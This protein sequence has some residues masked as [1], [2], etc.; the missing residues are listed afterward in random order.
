LC[1]HAEGLA[2]EVFESVDEI[3]ALGVGINLQPHAIRELDALG[4][5]ESVVEAGITPRQ[6]AYVTKRGQEIWREPRGVAAGYPW[7]QV[8]VHRGELQRILLDAF[9][10][11]IG[12]EHLHLGHRLVRVER[13]EERA[14]A[15]FANGL[16]TAAD[17]VVA[18]DGIHSALRSQMY[19]DEGPPKWS[20]ALLWRGVAE[21]PALLDGRTLIWAGHPA[22][23]FVAYPI[24]D[25]RDGRQLVNF[26]AE[27]RRPRDDLAQRED[28]NRRGDLDDFLPAFLGWDFGWL[29]VPATIRAADATYLFPMVDRDPLSSW[30]LGRAVLLGDAAHPM[31]PIGSNG[32]SQA[33]VDARVLAACLSRTTDVEAALATYESVRLPATSR[34]VTANRGMG[35]EL[36]MKLVEE[37]APDGFD[38]I[39]DVITPAEILEVTDGY[40]QASGMALSELQSG[41]SVVDH[42]EIPDRRGRPAASDEERDRAREGD[43]DRT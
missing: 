19:P 21:I 24:G 15:V 30:R 7:P 10:D 20:G 41:S 9:L 1:L 6:L 31:Y 2:V 29:D 16:E 28:W 22:Q 4:L 8:S 35:P 25:L 33:I 34:V 5:M 43:D 26:I 11:R 18:A 36:P 42:L 32:A 39:G 17:V 3:R 27:L 37:R 38:D 14:V 13:L 40:R 23:K 12:P